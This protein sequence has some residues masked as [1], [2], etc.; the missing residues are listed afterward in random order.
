MD[1]C[2]ESCPLIPPILNG[3]ILQCMNCT[4]AGGKITWN[5]GYSSCS[6][7][8]WTFSDNLS[9]NIYSCECIERFYNQCL[10]LYH[11]VYHYNATCDNAFRIIFSIRLVVII[12][13]LF[14]NA[15]ICYAFVKMT[16]SLR[17][18]NPNVLLHNQA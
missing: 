1:S 9:T 5:L 11:D 18:K 10:P 3:T 8:R 17:K 7:D 15:T 14:L 12:V 4:N 16:P 6:Q 2:E 13:A